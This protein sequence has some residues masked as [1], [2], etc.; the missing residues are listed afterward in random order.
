SIK[1]GS[2][3]IIPCMI[4]NFIETGKE[5][6]LNP[7]DTLKKLRDEK[8][9]QAFIFFILM[10]AV[11]TVLSTIVTGLMGV[12]GSLVF[13]LCG[14]ALG[15]FIGSIIGL[16]ITSVILHIFVY[17]LGGRNGIEQT[18][19]AVIYSF[20]PVAL[21][22]WIPL[23]GIIGLIWSFVLEILAIRELQDM[24]TAR[25]AIA[26]I[27]PLVILIV[28]AVILLMFFIVVAGAAYMQ[29]M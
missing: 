27:L 10:I 20:V 11:F 21:L 26:V 3:T 22:G 17:I 24:S 1:I 2:N 15:A 13:S 7:V 23:V 9:D 12:P 18:V 29:T 5:L 4:S 8:L 25:A 19:K 16:L 28:L 6:L 14:Y